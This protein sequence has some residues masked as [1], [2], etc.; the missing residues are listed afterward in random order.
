M[1]KLTTAIRNRY[2]EDIKFE[3]EE[4]KDWFKYESV[5]FD[6]KNPDL[7]IITGVKNLDDVFDSIYEL[8]SEATDLNVNSESEDKI[9]IDL[10][11]ATPEEF[12]DDSSKEPTK[13][14]GGIVVGCFGSGSSSLDGV[15]GD[16]LKK[17]MGGK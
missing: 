9:V 12:E 10:T 14:K 1:K 6:K 15:L 11:S 17:L 7:V 13:S 2:L 3:L 16:F 4:S 8:L 5:G